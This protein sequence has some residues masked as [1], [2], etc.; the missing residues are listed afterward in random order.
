MSVIK[1]TGNRSKTP[2]LIAYLITCIVLLFPISVFPFK[3]YFHSES[4]RYSPG[5]GEMK[6]YDLSGRLVQRMEVEPP[7]G[8]L[9]ETSIAFDLSHLPQG[10]YILRLDVDGGM[11]K[12]VLICR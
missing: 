5:L 10:L 2:H 9:G 8:G 12:K 4:A 11:S 3:G 6:V 7:N 1:K